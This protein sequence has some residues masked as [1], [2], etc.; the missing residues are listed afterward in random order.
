MKFEPE[1][2]TIVVRKEN[3][4]V[5]VIENELEKYL[6]KGYEVIN[7]TS[8]EKTPRKSVDESKVVEEKPERKRRSKK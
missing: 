2:R 8:E 6:S 7:K 1:P 5:K 3:R 4:I